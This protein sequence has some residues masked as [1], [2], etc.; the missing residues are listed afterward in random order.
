MKLLNEKMAKRF[1]YLVALTTTGM[2][3]RVARLDLRYFKEMDGRW[4]HFFNVT[5]YFITYVATY[6]LIA[7]PGVGLNDMWIYDGFYTMGNKRKR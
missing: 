6:T 2:K 4:L 3:A 5:I 7:L 1:N